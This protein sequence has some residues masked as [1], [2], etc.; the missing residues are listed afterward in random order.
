MSDIKVARRSFLKLAALG[1]SSTMAFSNEND[2]LQKM[3]ELNG[4]PDPYPGSK[5]VRTICSICSAGCGIEAEV[6]NGV[7]VRQDMAVSHPISQGSHCCKGIDQIDLTKSKQRIKYPMKKVNG[8][9]ERISWETAINEIGDKM[10]EIR[11]QHGPDCVEFLGS[12]KFSNEQSW[13]FRKFAAFWGS[14][15]IDH[16]ARI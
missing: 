2:T 1:A 15:N 11:K 6:H 10:L 5:R 14:N 9:W 13:Y 12:A 4:A 16:V 3:S 8:K 7:W